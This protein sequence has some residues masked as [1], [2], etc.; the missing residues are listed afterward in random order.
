MSH[1]DIKA[2]L[3]DLAGYLGRWVRIFVVQVRTLDEPYD[4]PVPSLDK[5]T[6]TRFGHAET[7]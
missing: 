1:L 6:L 5:G 4:G 3:A 7:A 2:I